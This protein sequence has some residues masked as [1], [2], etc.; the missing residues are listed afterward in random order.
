LTIDREILWKELRGKGINNQ[1]I[2]RIKK[3]YGETEVVV[4]TREGYT[5]E[6]KT[7]KGVRQGCVMSP[8]LFNVYMADLDNKMRR[9]DIGGVGIKGNRI[10]SLA[11]AD[12]IA[13][14]ANNREA[15][16]DMMHTF[17]SFLKEKKL[18]L[19]MEKR[20]C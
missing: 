20:R 6:F 17:K 10:W 18:E 11:Y 8:I 12:D 19:C 7:R 4:R 15:M 3:I 5:E 13:L 2:G 9:R 16:L 1:L 14:I